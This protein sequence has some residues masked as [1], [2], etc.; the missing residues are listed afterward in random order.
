MTAMKTIKRV[1]PA[2]E[3]DM[4]GIPVLQPF[5]TMSTEQIDPF[6][7]LHHSKI[8]APQGVHPLQAGI[9]P[10]PHR[11]FM[12]VSYVVKGSL[13]HRDS[14]GN[15][16]IINEGGAQWLNAGRGIVH[17]ERPSKEL[18]QKGGAVEVVQVWINLPAA[19]KLSA[20]EYFGLEAAALPRISLGEGFNLELIAGTYQGEK[21]P[22]RTPFPLLFAVLKSENHKGRGFLEWEKNM[23]GGIYVVRGSAQLEGYG[24]LEEKQFYRF[25]PE[26]S[27]AGLE[28]REGFLALLMLGSPINESL[29]T[30]GPFVMN[31]QTEVMEALRDYNQGKMGILIE[32]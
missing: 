15:S 12:P 5:P 29:A 25:D 23:E 14:L 22:V 4:G 21:S 32:E 19:H 13:H 10:H 17:S 7:L 20:P 1:F 31:S 28:A 8:K 26:F 2:Q 9:G 6:L 18:A 11:G 24:P 30:Y 27:E 3:V 16:S